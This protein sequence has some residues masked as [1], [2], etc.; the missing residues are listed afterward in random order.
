MYHPDVIMAWREKIALNILILFACGLLLFYII[1][2]G[3]IICPKQYVKSQGE[4]DGKNTVNDPYVSIYGSYYHIPPI[5]KSHVIE[6]GWLNE[7]AMQDTTL[8]HDVSAMFFKTTVWQ[9]YCPNLPQP[10]GWDNIER[11]VPEKAITVWNFHNAKDASG[12]LI[13]YS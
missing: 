12:N 4:I 3:R 6:N 2:L 10:S 9:N 8:G 13:Y 11:N 1:G 5:I 7:Q